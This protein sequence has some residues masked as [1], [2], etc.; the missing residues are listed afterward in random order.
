MEILEP[1]SGEVCTIEYD[2]NDAAAASNINANID[3]AWGD[4]EEASNTVCYPLVFANKGQLEE[5]LEDWNGR[6]GYASGFIGCINGD[7]KYPGIYENLNLKKLAAGSKIVGKVTMGYGAITDIS[8]LMNFYKY[9]DGN[10][11]FLKKLKSEAY[12]MLSATCSDGFNR[13]SSGKFY[14]FDEMLNEWVRE[15]LK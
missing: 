4:L 1:T 11:E 15:E 5:T 14:Q 6:L 12:G 7:S 10:L 8:D 3:I 13:L 9:R 2:L